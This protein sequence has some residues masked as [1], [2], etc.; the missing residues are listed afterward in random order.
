M[1]K[2]VEETHADLLRQG[3]A[4]DM[5]FAFRGPSVKLI[6]SQSFDMTSEEQKAREEVIN[7]IKKFTQKSNINMEACSVATRL[8]GVDNETIISEI[9]PVGNTFVSLIGYQNKGYALIPLY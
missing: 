5:V 9:S 6:S 8:L 4:P 2:V 1:F 3:V 7:W